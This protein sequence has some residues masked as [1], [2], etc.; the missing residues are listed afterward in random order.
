MKS[1]GAYYTEGYVSLILEYMDVGSLGFV[2]KS[3]NKQKRRVPETALA[4]I[5]SQVGWRHE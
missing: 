4:T 3:M 5:V 2:I 1:Y